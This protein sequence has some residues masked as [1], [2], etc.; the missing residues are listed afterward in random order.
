MFS[1]F[2]YQLDLG[3]GDQN[4]KPQGSEW[5]Y[6]RAAVVVLCTYMNM[7]AL[8]H[9]TF[10]YSPVFIVI[11]QMLGMISKLNIECCSP[12]PK[13]LWMDEI[14]VRCVVG[15]PL[16]LSWIRWC[17]YWTWSMTLFYN[18]GDNLNERM[19]ELY[20]GVCVPLSL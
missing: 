17:W 2:F 10:Q 11:Y 12:V 3:V 9:Y 19:H 14:K 7:K 6:R 13:L 18:Y 4:E 8:T 5:G 1:F 15:A 20:A 16:S